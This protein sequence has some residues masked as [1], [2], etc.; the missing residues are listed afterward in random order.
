VVLYDEEANMA[1]DLAEE[2]PTDVCWGALTGKYDKAQAVWIIDSGATRHMTYLRDVF[3]DYVQ[4]KT[5]KIV[6]TANN[7]LV[8]GFGIGNVHVQVFTDDLRVETLILT[9]VLYVPDLAGNLISVSQL[10]EKG[11]LV[12]TTAGQ[13]HPMVLTRNGSTVAFAARIGSQ[14]IL[15]SVATEATMAAADRGVPNLDL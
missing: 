12:Q 8:Y 7:G 11:T 5:P 2:T 9:D 1:T 15:D 4:L 13:K 14:Y 10:Q 6:K 3:S